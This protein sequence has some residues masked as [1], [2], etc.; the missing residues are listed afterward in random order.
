M[1][2]AATKILVIDDEP[3]VRRAVALTIELQEPA[4][5]VLSAS[6]GEEGLELV[7][8]GSPDLVLLDLQMP[9]TDGFAV[10][11]QLRAFS[12]VPVVILTVRDD[13]L[14]KVRGLQMGADDYVVKPFSHLELLARIRSVLRRASGELAASEPPFVLDGLR[15]EWG[16]HRVYRRGER[17]RLTATEF[18]LLELVARN[19]GHVVPAEVL[20]ARVW[21]PDERD[22]TDYL[23]TYVH[24]LR[25]KLE[26]DP[27]A[28]RYLQ[29]ERGVGYWL[30]R[31]RPIRADDMAQ[32]RPHS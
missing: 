16:P 27:G 7:E 22:Q 21:G 14:D 17:V 26:D 25:V 3:D 23:K 2:T 29:T 31:P 15:I 32:P 9:G 1:D 11:E 8:T 5:Q 28:P 18:R 4:W 24:R 30:P 20:L 12:D 13:E 10:L 6:S 19:A